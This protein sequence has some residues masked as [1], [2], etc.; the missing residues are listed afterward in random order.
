LIPQLIIDSQPFTHDFLCANI[1]D[2]ILLD[3]L[4]QLIKGIFK[5]HLVMWVCNYL[6]KVYGETQ[7]NAILND[8]DRWY[9]PP[10]THRLTLLWCWEVLTYNSI[11]A[12]PFFPG[13]CQF[14]QGR[15]LKQW[16]GDDSKALMKV[17][18]SLHSGPMKH[19]SQTFAGISPCNC[20]L[21]LRRDYKVYFSFPRHMLHCPT[22]RHQ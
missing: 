5:D 20:R 8:I 16:M 2:M 10:T 9:I 18:L 19:F 7:A 4:H 15:H 3:M 17:C 22:T 12:V 13:L 11:A 21:C 1:Y 6:L 14:P